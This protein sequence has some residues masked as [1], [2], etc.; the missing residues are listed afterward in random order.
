[1]TRSKAVS[2]DAE[3]RT[4]NGTFSGEVSVLRTLVEELKMGVY[5]ADARG[6]LLYINNAFVN[7]LGYQNKDEILGFYFL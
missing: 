3:R 4:R 2:R 6:N 5:M 1:M 7:I